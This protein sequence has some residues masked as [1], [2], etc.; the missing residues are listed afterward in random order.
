M[1]QLGPIHGP[2]GIGTE[3]VDD[4]SAEADNGSFVIFASFRNR[5]NCSIVTSL[6]AMAKRRG[7]TNAPWRFAR[8]R[9]VPARSAATP[10]GTRPVPRSRRRSA[11]DR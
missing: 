8:C 3:L 2:S 9:C 11:P 1:Y 5:W 6:V 4:R 10:C 7:M